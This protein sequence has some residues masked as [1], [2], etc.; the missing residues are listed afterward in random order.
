MADNGLYSGNIGQDGGASHAFS[1]SIDAGLGTA[2]LPLA[3][4]VLLISPRSS[5][6]APWR[7]A[8][9]QCLG[10]G[11]LRDA[12]EASSDAAL[13]KSSRQASVG[14][15]RATRRKTMLGGYFGAS[16]M[17]LSQ[18][19]LNGAQMASLAIT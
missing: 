2:W 1:M 5:H 8:S 19:S 15:T 18:L 11:R 13:M 9:C 6:P 12:N 7:R 4:M 14:G 3:W 17:C 16:R 10:G